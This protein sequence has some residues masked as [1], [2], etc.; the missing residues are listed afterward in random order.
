MTLPGFVRY[1]QT[2]VASDPTLSAVFDADTLAQI[3][4]LAQYTDADTVAKQ[5]TVAELSGLMPLTLRL[6]S[7]LRGCSR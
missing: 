5:M 7:S 3:N 6:P 1:I 2:D 4:M